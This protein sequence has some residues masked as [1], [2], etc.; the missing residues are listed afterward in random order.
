MCFHYNKN[1][2]ISFNLLTVDASLRHRGHLTSILPK[3]IFMR[4]LI[5]TL[6]FFCCSQSAFAQFESSKQ[7]YSAPG[8]KDSLANHK[9]VA[10]LP[11]RVTISYKRMPK[12]F[13]AEANKQ[14]EQ[15]AGINL[16][17]G[18]YT[19]LLRKS[20]KYS[21]SFQETERTNILLK[22]AGVDEKLDEI[23]PDSLAKLLGV[24]AVIRCSYAY[25]RTGSEAGAIA[26][27]VL[28]G[29][30][31]KTGSGGLTMQIYNGEG[32]GLLWRFYKEMNENISSNGNEIMERMMRKVSRNFPYEKK[33]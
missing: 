14:D 19:F 3:T 29:G 20:D 12:N 30:A 26:K 21:V 15:K 4:F 9:I 13:D 5:F 16:Q 33:K 23:L 1:H 17:Q 31:G 32:G 28:V 27:V 8:L 18:M 2:N 24:D 11:F 6:L 22:K 25:E 7:V 10:I